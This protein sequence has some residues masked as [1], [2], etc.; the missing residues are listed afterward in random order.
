M[1][2]AGYSDEQLFEIGKNNFE[3]LALHCQ[4]LEVSG[5]WEQA[6]SVMKKSSTEMLD[7]YVQSV[8]M[9]L[10]VDC[11]NVLDSQLEFIRTVTISNPL[12]IHP[13]MELGGEAGKEA[14]K[15]FKLPPV[16]IQLCSLYDKEKKDDI[17]EYF[18]DALLNILLCMT[19]LN[20]GK[21]AQVDAFIRQYYSKICCF[22]GGRSQ[23]E[24]AK[25]IERKLGSVEIVCH[26][27]KKAPPKK[28][29]VR[30][31]EQ[32]VDRIS[33]QLKNAAKK[34]SGN[35]KNLQTKE[36]EGRQQDSGAQPE[37]TL[38]AQERHEPKI[39]R[40]RTKKQ[41]KT[42]KRSKISGLE[43]KKAVSEKE[44]AVWE[45]VEHTKKEAAK[46]EEET[47]AVLSEREASQEE[48]S[49]VRS[50]REATQD[51]TSAV[52]PEREA[53]QDETS[54]VLPE[55]EATQ[56][57]ASAIR[58]EQEAS[59]DE[60][61]AILPERETS[62]DETSAILPERET[63]QKKKKKSADKTEKGAG[64]RPKEKITPGAENRIVD[65]AAAEKVRRE[66]A[67]NARKEAA[68]RAREAAVR[69][70]EQEEREQELAKQQ[71]L[72]V[73]KRIQ[74]RELEA[75]RV[76][77]EK[78]GKLVGL[79][80][81]KEEI[82]SLINLIKIRKL[83]QQMNLPEMDMSY[84][85][86]FTGSPG[87]GK[88]TVARLVAKIYKELGILSDGKLV[89]TD[90][91][92]LVAGYVGQTAIKVHEIVE[93]ALGGVLFID[94]AYSLT[95]PDIPNDFGG[96]AVD[97]LV[98]LMEDHRDD[99]VV[100]VA[101]YTREMKEFLKSNTGLISRFNKF[102][103]FPDYS[104]SELVA[105]M[106][107]MAQNAGLQI[108][109]KAKEKVRHILAEKG[110]AEKQEFGNARG[111]RNLFEKLVINQANRLVM[112]SNPTEED[113]R[114]IHEEDVVV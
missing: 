70:K 45:T 56:G 5:F 69:A 74:D 55:R 9:K 35:S 96:E 32:A 104:D 50:E 46:R 51:E 61:S 99:L 73:K 108:D 53:T 114:M 95:N 27:E 66:A 8:L 59:Q 21:N 38:T 3:R 83:R 43:Q 31:M 89:E 15:L 75:E 92:G 67:V 78:I 107:V 82:Q 12:N 6:R 58:P 44:N 112:I 11:Q 72:L 110:K 29:T 47:S 22:V 65:K 85:M 18:V 4:T 30:E 52:L 41:K 10:A 68:A 90:R 91:S 20:E 37:E 109:D 71:F 87:T 49:A 25:Y 48:K 100:I 105:I 106:E 7:T 42:A 86:V 81:V 102:I 1:A 97:T 33:G 26:V 17:T 113:L 19:Y 34:A 76:K 60:T 36:A 79:A 94:E 39:V 57:E 54:A 28:E 63:V 111:I 23:A 103:D 40:V 14:E 24:H 64:V 62:Q 101:G 2:Q 77:E 80:N 88:T 13:G 98:K 93:Q 16:L 84:H